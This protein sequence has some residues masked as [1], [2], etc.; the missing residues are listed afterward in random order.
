LESFFEFVKARAQDAVHKPNADVIADFVDKFLVVEMKRLSS[1]D[2]TY[3]EDI[4]FPEDLV[5][6]PLKEAKRKMDDIFED[7]LKKG[8]SVTSAPTPTTSA[9]KTSAPVDPSIPA[10]ARPRNGNGHK[11]EKIRSLLDGEK[12]F[13]RTNF[14]ALNGQIKDDVCVE[15]KQNAAIG[16]EVGIFQVTGF[17]TYLHGRVAAGELILNDLPAYLE[18]IKG[19]RDLWARY[20]SPKYAAMRSN[21]A[22]RTPQPNIAAA[23]PPNTSPKFT[24]FP[25]R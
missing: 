2:E 23:T 24:N 21:V 19:H 16:T 13:I 8:S 3:T 18:F 7:F 20:N 25:K 1:K 9:P 5:L 14:A 15:M 10:V 17:V 12:D 22:S 6:E 4:E 11:K